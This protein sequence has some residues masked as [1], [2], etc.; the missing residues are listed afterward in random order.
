MIIE[1]VVIG[2]DLMEVEIATE[3]DVDE[4]SE[5]LV[6]GIL[7]VLVEA[8]SIM[9]PSEVVVVWLEALVVDFADVDICVLET[10]THSIPEH[11]ILLL[12]IVVE[13]IEGVRHSVP[14]HI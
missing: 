12:S 13:M 11:L 6:V 2:L 10:D 14:V 1:G 7:L 8:V 4:V 3:A 9:F 5:L